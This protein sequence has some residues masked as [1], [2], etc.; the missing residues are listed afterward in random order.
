MISL[1]T[2]NK[3]YFLFFVVTC[4]S[5]KAQTSFLLQIGKAGFCEYP[6]NLVELPNGNFIVASLISDDYYET[7]EQ[8]LQIIGPNGELLSDIIIEKE[9]AELSDLMY[10]ND[11]LIVGVGN[12]KRN[13]TLF[14]WYLGFDCNL[15]ITFDK[16]YA[17]KS[18]RFLLTRSFIDSR[19]HINTAITQS[20]AD[21]GSFFVKANLAGDTLFTFR[22]NP[23]LFNIN[24]E[25]L[26]HNDCYR[27]F[28]NYYLG[29]DI[30]VQLVDSSFNLIQNDTIPFGISNGITAKAI[31][32]NYYYVAGRGS[33]L[34]DDWNI[35]IEKLNYNDSLIAMNVVDRTDLPDFPASYNCLDFIDP[36]RVFLASMAP[37]DGSTIFSNI[38]NHF[39]LHLYDSSL[40]EIWTRKWGGDAY[41]RPSVMYAT[42]DGG[43]I[44]AG[45]M[46]DYQQMDML[47]DI[48]IMKVD[49][50]GLVTSSSNQLV[51]DHKFTIYPNPGKDDF[52]ITVNKG[53]IP[54]EFYMYDS[55]GRKILNRNILSTENCIS[56]G[57]FPSGLYFWVLVKD[58]QVWE[59]GK[60]IKN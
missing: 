21:G 8:K 54:L 25:F 28:S 32:T 10:Y 58:G 15:N 40:N 37:F 1:K 12:H 4:F 7:K 23:P 57:K 5:V 3:I 53:S 20:V 41:Y 31:D 2:F 11:S 6:T 18:D 50:Q 27:L 19:N 39:Y 47:D 26:E 24:F 17:S 43:A 48:F 52:T 29:E 42:M 49:Q 46:Y 59:T 14:L 34:I 55:Q 30:G 51:K 16:E 22:R 60:W 35:V 38:Y 45:S 44:I 13:D 9:D 56:A 33:L 36:N